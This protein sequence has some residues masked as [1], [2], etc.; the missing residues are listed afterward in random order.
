MPPPAAIAPRKPAIATI[1]TGDQPAVPA[2]V[3]TDT[4]PAVPRP[5]P[6]ERMQGSVGAGRGSASQHDIRLVQSY[7]F[8]MGYLSQAQVTGR[9]NAASEADPTVSAIRQFQGHMIAEFNQSQGRTGINPA[10]FGASQTPDGIISPNGTTF[11]N[12][13]RSLGANFRNPDSIVAGPADGGAITANPVPDSAPNA[14]RPTAPLAASGP[15]DASIIEQIQ[16]RLQAMGYLNTAQI[17]GRVQ[18]D[19]DGETKADDPTVMALRE[20]ADNTGTSIS[21]NAPSL[22][23]LNALTQAANHHNPEPRWTMREMAGRPFAYYESADSFLT[24]I[25]VR[26]TH[27]FGLQHPI[28]ELGGVYQGGQEVAQGDV[29][30]GVAHIVSGVIQTPLAAPAVL[31]EMADRGLAWLERK[32]PSGI[33]WVIS[34]VRF[35]VG[36]FQFAANIVNFAGQLA[37]VL[38]NALLW[39]IIKPFELLGKW[40]ASKVRSS[41]NSTPAE[42]ARL[43]A[44][45]IR[46]MTIADINAFLD[47][48]DAKAELNAN[49]DAN[50]NALLRELRRRERQTTTAGGTAGAN[51]ASGAANNDAPAA[52]VPPA[53]P[54]PRAT[55]RAR[56][57]R[58]GT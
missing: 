52:E 24:G 54:A 13:K 48:L 47:R 20:F 27:L 9:M 43:T 19:D 15:A 45:Q 21:D 6:T 1:P 18:T 36:I 41:N 51:G 38:V 23:D 11:N 17:T 7:L 2:T 26:S 31:I 49:D 8:H 57:A 33:R 22:E 56:P 5:A 3:V 16:R 37:G 58:T 32:A 55:R 28:F 35:F 10:V 42:E 30:E 4:R 25:G 53:I 40:I 39:A 50:Y 34:V 44:A 46:A 12:L 29:A 14:T